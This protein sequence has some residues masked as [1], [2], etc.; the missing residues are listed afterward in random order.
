MSTY[1]KFTSGQKR[2]YLFMFHTE[3]YVFILSRHVEFWY[4][5]V[6]QKLQNITNLFSVKWWFVFWWTFISSFFFM[7]RRKDVWC[8][9]AVQQWFSH[10]SSFEKKLLKSSTI[11]FEILMN[12]QFPTS[13]VE[14]TFSVTLRTEPTNKL[15][16]RLFY[17]FP[18][19]YVLDHLIGVLSGAK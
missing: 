12:S 10:F 19:C 18:N 2:F 7:I 6:L 8:H 15:F 16:F 17:S 1:D 5:L 11:S 13:L 4:I 3:L 9:N 14:I